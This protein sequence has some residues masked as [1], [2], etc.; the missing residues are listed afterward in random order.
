VRTAESQAIVQPEAAIREVQRRQSNR[1]TLP[2][3]LRQ[4]EVSGRVPRKVLGT[5]TIS[6]PRPVVD[7]SIS[8]RTP[9]Q[10]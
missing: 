9:R 8:P 6:E 2:K 3:I 5:A 7:V 4:R 10:G 1:S